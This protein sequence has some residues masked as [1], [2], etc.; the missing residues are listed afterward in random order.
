MLV[1]YVEVHSRSLNVLHYAPLPK[2]DVATDC[3][4]GIRAGIVVAVFAEY[5]GLADRE[6]LL[7][8]AG[9]NEPG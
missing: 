8:D 7:L 2:C 6:P 9:L 4:A 5:R 1:N 3:L